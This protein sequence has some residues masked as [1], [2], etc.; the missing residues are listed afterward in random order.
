M[1]KLEIYLGLLKIPLDLFLVVLAFLSVYH[2]RLSN[3]VG[4][5]LSPVEQV[6]FYFVKDNFILDYALPMA[7][8]VVLMFGLNR[9][10]SFKDRDESLSSEI[11]VIFTSTIFWLS[12]V[13]SYFFVIRDFPF[14][15]FVLLGSAVV[16]FVF[17]SLGRVLIFR[18]KSNLIKRGFG[19][20][21]VVLVVS[22]KDL[23]KKVVLAFKADYRYKVV[24]YIADKKVL[25]FKLKYLGSF[26]SIENVISNYNFDHLVQVGDLDSNYKN[27]DLVDSCRAYHKE[28]QFL[29]EIYDVQKHNLKL[30]EI[31]GLPIFKIKPTPLDG[32]SRVLKRA[33]DLVVSF[34]L[35]LILFPLMLFVSLL[36]KLDSKGPILFKYNDNGDT[37]WRIGS[38]GKRFYCLKFRTM[39]TGTHELRYS[40]LASKN[41]RKGPLVKI[42]DDPRVTKLGKFLRRFDIDELPQLWNVFIGEMSLVGPRPHLVEEV[43]KYLKHHKF[44]LTVK[45]GITGMAQVSGRSDLEFE[46]EVKL[47]T[48]YIENWSMWLDFRILLKTVLVVLGGH[49]EFKSK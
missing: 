25:N 40:E 33:F 1:K 43:D 47:D 30:S 8:S 14:S 31:S 34:V 32:W 24:G 37:V 26:D 5:F 29:P 7:V 11:R 2:F 35:M 28:Y 3:L 42:K 6:S 45:P 17:V 41:I 23:L 20:K 13:I 27:Q 9:L 46:D 15:R 19:L 16:I 22:N 21:K 48:Y 38:K 10:Y 18:L 49:G 44:V 39:F 12:L 4:N 36:I